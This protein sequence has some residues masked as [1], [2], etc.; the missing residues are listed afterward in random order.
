MP[1]TRDSLASYVN[2]V[3]QQREAIVIEQLTSTVQRQMERSLEEFQMQFLVSEAPTVFNTPATSANSQSKVLPSQPVFLDPT[4]SMSIPTPSTVLASTSE[5]I[6]EVPRTE[7]TKTSTKSSDSLAKNTITF[8]SQVSK[9][10]MA[11]LDSILRSEYLLSPFDGT[12]L[13]SVSST[14]NLLILPTLRLVFRLSSKLMIY[15]TTT[16]I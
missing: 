3:L 11:H 9:R 7:Y 16:M 8:Q 5:K 10:K 6:S 1:T 2:S 13:K 14:D 4:T 12:R 15:F